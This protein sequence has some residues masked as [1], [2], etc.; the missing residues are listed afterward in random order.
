MAMRAAKLMVHQ[1][2]YYFTAGY[3]RLPALNDGNFLGRN[4]FKIPPVIPLGPTFTYQCEE[5]Y[6]NTTK[7]ELFCD[8]NGWLN[9][10]ITP[11]CIGTIC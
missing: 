1:T 8:S 5:G 7:T 2:V 4:G 9:G 11:Q 3:C 6:V 10:G